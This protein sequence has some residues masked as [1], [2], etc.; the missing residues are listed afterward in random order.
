M[1]K[2]IFV[3]AAVLALAGCN[4]VDGLGQDISS[5]SQAVQDSF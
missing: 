3:V 5:T 2:S 4:T 1:K